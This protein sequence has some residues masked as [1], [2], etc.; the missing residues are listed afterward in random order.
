MLENFIHTLAAQF[1]GKTVKNVGVSLAGF[2]LTGISLTFTDGTFVTLDVYGE[3]LKMQAFN[4]RER[5]VFTT[6]DPIDI[7]SK[8]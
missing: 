6:D 4:D 2:Q 7:Y 1:K 3:D 5:R 8:A